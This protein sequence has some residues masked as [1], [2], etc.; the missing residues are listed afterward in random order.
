MCVCVCVVV[1][2]CVCVCVCV[3]TKVRCKPR[4]MTNSNKKIKTLIYLKFVIS[5]RSLYLLAPYFCVYIY[6]AQKVG[7][8]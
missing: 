4:G 7:N 2:V 8:H 6:Q 5:L 1:C 3:N